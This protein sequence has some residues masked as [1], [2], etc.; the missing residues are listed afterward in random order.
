M[1][2]HIVHHLYPGIPNH[3]TKD[4]YYEMKPILAQRG[5]DCSPL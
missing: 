4:A 2:Y 3:A 5:V 1:Q